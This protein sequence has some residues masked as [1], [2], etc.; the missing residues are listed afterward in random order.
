MLNSAWLTFTVAVLL[1]SLIARQPGLLI[2]GLA[3]L[4]AEGVSLLWGRYALRGVVYE[5]ALSE[6]RAF[7]GDEVVLDVRTENRKPLPLAWL[8]IEDEFPSALRLRRGRL[9]PSH[10]PRRAMLN[11]LLTLRWYE[12][13]TRRYPVECAARGEHIFGPAKLRTGDIFGFVD[14]EQELAAVQRLLVYPRV[15]PVV[16]APIPSAHLLGPLKA[17]RRIVDDPLRTAGVREYAP[18]DNPRRI[19]WKVSARRGELYSRLL[20]PST[21]IDLL[22]FLNVS[23]V[24]PAWLGVIEDRLELAVIVT[25]SLAR[26]QLDAGNPVGLFANSDTGGTGQPLRILPGSDPRQFSRILEGCARLIGFEITAFPRFLARE[27]RNLP[28]GATL[29]VVTGVLGDELAATL[30]RLR[31]AGRSVALVLVGD[32]HERPLIPGVPAFVVR[33]ERE[34]REREAIELA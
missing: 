19:H 2:V 16:G 21:T 28:W 1:A 11:G 15:L 26:Q 18:G 31:R 3:L 20:E 22:L 14:R 5:R 7:F 34:W 8:S 12:R 23:T 29:V 27:A 9:A 30:L 24:D 32:D 6:P 13:V 25:A 33:G 4:L 17:R 10:K